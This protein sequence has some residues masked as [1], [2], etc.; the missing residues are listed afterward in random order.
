MIAVPPDP[1]LRMRRLVLAAALALSVTPALAGP[2]WITVEYP[3][4]PLDPRTR[5]AYLVVHAWHHDTPAGLPV[6][7]TAVGVVN[8][9]RRTIALRFAPTGRTGAYALSRQWPAE[10]R[11]MLHLVAVQGDD[12]DGHAHALVRLSPDGGI[13]GVTVPSRREGRH[14][15][16]RAPTT[17][18]LEAMLR[19]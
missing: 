13:A 3:G 18:E 15:V 17:Q 16:P 5:D 4:N 10:G 11:W 19:D 7:G 8:G 1:E 12:A 6:K 2:P 9:E 14:V